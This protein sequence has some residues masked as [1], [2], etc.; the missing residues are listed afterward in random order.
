MLSVI[1]LILIIIALI[2]IGFA[3]FSISKGEKEFVGKDGVNID[4]VLTFSGIILLVFF[5]LMALY[6]FT[7]E[8]LVKKT[9]MIDNIGEQNLLSRNRLSS[10]SKSN[11]I[12][13]V[14]GQ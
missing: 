5:V 2:G 12:S 14:W 9:L 7:V 3:S 1:F 13:N 4:F 10:N 11:Q 8:F 6:A